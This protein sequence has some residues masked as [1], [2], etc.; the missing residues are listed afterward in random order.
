MSQHFDRFN[1]NIA[2]VDNLNLLFEHAKETKK[3]PTVKE[4]DILRAS[5]V[6]LHSALEDYLRAVLIE[7]IPIV[8]DKGTIDG[9]ALPDNDG[10][11]KQFLLGQLL[12][13]RAQTVDALIN[14]AVAR[15]MQRVSFNDTTDICSWMQKV[16]ISTDGFAAYEK[17][18]NMIVRRHKIVHEADTNPQLGRGYHHATS[19][20]LATVSAWRDAVVTFVSYIDEQL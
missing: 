20:N 3:R 11:P 14:D 13:Y 12:Q 15:H 8:G 10:R 16:S 19:I 6:F 17:L 7:R 1:G 4:A 5:V 2:R 18:N 9:I